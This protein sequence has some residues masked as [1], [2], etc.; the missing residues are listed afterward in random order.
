[1]YK[2]YYRTQFQEVLPCIHVKTNPIL[3][4]YYLYTN[5]IAP[6][7]CLKGS[8]GVPKGILRHNFD[9]PSAIIIHI[10]RYHYRYGKKARLYRERKIRQ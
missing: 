9:A 6:S 1:M 2:L 8:F 7:V 5:S 4:L 3:S 10:C